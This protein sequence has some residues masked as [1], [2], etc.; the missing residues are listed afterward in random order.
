VFKVEEAISVHRNTPSSLIN[1]D[2]MDAIIVRDF[3][4]GFVAFSQ[5][6][7][8]QGY[9]RKVCFGQLKTVA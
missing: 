1:S 2:G 6:G 4:E 5:P 9:Y 3:V 8:G 7:F